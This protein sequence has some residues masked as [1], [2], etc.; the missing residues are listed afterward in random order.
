MIFA[1]RRAWIHIDHIYD[2][3]REDN[4]T[5]IPRSSAMRGDLVLYKNYKHAPTHIGL[6]IDVQRDTHLGNKVD[7]MTVLSKWGQLA[8]FI[9]AIDNVI[10]N[11]GMASAFYTDRK[12]HDYIFDIRST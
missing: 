12:T 5:E 9:H 4:Y 7:N 10:S 3:L 2:L 6:I 8:E 11:L 1:G